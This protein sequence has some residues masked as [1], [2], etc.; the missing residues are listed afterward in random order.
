MVRDVNVQLAPDAIGA[1]PHRRLPRAHGGDRDRAA[2]G[3]HPGPGRARVSPIRFPCRRP[4]R[5]ATSARSATGSTRRAPHL[6]R[7]AGTLDELRSRADNDDRETVVALLRQ[8]RARPDIVESVAREVDALLLRLPVPAAAYADQAAEPARRPP[9]ASAPSRSTSSARS[10]PTSAASH[11]TPILGLGLTDSL[12]GSRQ[13]LAREWARTF[14]FPMAR[15]QQDD[16][17][18][19]AQFVN[20]HDR[21]RH[22]ARRA[23]P[24]TCATSWPTRYPDVVAD[25]S[26]RHAR[27]AVAAA[28]DQHRADAPADPHVVLASAAVPDLRHRPPVEPPRRGAAGE[29]KEPVVDVCR[30]RPDVYD[31]PPSPCSIEPGYVPSPQRP[32][33]FHVF[34]NL[35]WPGVA[36]A[37]RG[38][39]LRLPHRRHRGLVA[40]PAPGATG[41]GR[42]G[43]AVPRLRPRG[44]GRAGPAAQPGEPG[45]SAQAAQVHPRGRADRPGRRRAVTGAGAALPRAVLRQVPPAVDRHLLGIGRRVRRRPRGRVEP[46]GDDRD[47]TDRAAGTDDR[48]PQPLRRPA[49]VPLRRGALRPRPGDRRAARPAHRRADRAALLAVGRRQD[50]AARGR[51]APRAGPTRLP[52]AADHPRRPRGRLARW[53]AR[54]A[55]C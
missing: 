12:I 13:L 9:P 15:H 16:L 38:R 10:S 44:L 14:E 31:W 5:S 19:V 32:L 55:T 3:D 25:A 29:G 43:A 51:A 50:V 8:L 1:H 33:V 37:H 24:S 27:R 53:P 2:D 18:Q 34:G 54:T 41:A 40:R 42:L 6:R 48:A 52:R 45:G 35:D 23:S 20:G 49:L 7:A 46:A 30:W 26:R 47:V 17:P 36:R 11:F 22:A 21:R 39:L 4:R 28:W